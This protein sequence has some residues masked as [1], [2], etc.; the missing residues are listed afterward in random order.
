VPSGRSVAAPFASRERDEYLPSTSKYRGLW[1]SV[2]CREMP[3]APDVDSALKRAEA[4]SREVEYMGAPTRTCANNPP[5]GC[6]ACRPSRA[7]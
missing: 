7:R 2:Y 6:R 4:M 1:D 5:A 3:P